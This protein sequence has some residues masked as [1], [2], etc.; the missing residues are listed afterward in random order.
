MQRVRTQAAYGCAMTRQ[1][2]QFGFSLVELVISL[3]FAAIVA[4]I[5][6]PALS[7][8][9]AQYQLMGASNQ[10]GFEIAR[11][12]MQAIAQNRFI[13]VKMSGATQYV[14]QISVDGSTWSTQMTSTLPSGV[15]STTTSA[16]VRFDKRGFATVNQSI[17]VSNTLRNAKTLSTSIVGRVT[18]A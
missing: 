16:E 8:F 5:A 3:Q 13:R 11:A 12:R 1:N 18:I 4:L 10:L 7:S 9:S 2:S 15:T 6:A 14:R 17:V